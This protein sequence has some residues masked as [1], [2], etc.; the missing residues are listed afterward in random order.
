MTILVRIASV[1]V[2][3]ALS[4]LA[5][6]LPSLAHAQLESS[7]PADGAQL[8]APPKKVQLTFG[9]RVDGGFAKVAVIGPNRSHWEAAKPAVSGAKVSA[10]VRPLGP[11]GTYV[12][13]YRVL[14][15]D[16]HPVSGSLKFTLTKPGHGTPAPAPAGGGHA[17]AAQGEPAEDGVPIWVWIAG[18]VAVFAVGGAAAAFVTRGAKS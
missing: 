2:I 14:S 6:A 3:V 12:I 18:A 11:A 8:S 4:L 9:E 1:L 16:G 13:E 17:A 15:A 5:S 10:P 7:N